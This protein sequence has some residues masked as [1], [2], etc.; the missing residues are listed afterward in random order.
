MKLSLEII[1][2]TKQSAKQSRFV[3]SGRQSALIREAQA[4]L[5]NIRQGV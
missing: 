5:F 3:F 1:Y 2:K 4:L